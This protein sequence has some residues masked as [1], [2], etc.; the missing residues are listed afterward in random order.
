MRREHRHP[1][2]EQKLRREQHQLR[3]AESIGDGVKR[4]FAG[5]HQLARG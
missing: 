5:N 3:L 4:Y 2:E 1:E